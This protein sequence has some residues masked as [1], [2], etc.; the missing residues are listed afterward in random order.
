MKFLKTEEVRIVAL[1]I[2]VVG[3]IVASG[4]FGYMFIEGWSFLDSLY[5]TIITVSTVGFQE[6]KPISLGGRILTIFIIVFAIS[7]L[8]Y[9]LTR[10]V[11]I[12]VE[13]KISALLRGRKMEKQIAKLKDHFI[14]C[15]YGKMGKQ[16]AYEFQNMQVPYVV[17]ELNNKA[18]EGNGDDTLLS[19][20]GDATHEEDLERCGI[21]HARGLVSVLREDSQNVYVVLTAR[22]LNADLRIVTRASEYESERKLKR[23]GADYVISPFKIGGS[24]IASVMLRPT[25]THFLDGLAKAEDI[26]LTLIEIEVNEESALLGKTIKETGIVNVQESIIVAIRRLTEPIKIRP[27]LDTRLK[28]GDQLII[29]GRIDSLQLVDEVV[30][31][32]P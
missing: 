25:I 20:V 19:L 1:T 28:V 23:A 26:R 22:G 21:C 16:V 3:G 13:G 10:F 24:R 15:G 31:M 18:F 27:S 4:V 30:Q 2:I 17:I 7:S 6:V 8:G 14:I 32:K 12:M 29:M 5:Q 9:F 11:T